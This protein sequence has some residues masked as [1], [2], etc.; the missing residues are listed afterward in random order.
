MF[1][2]ADAC[3][4]I[5]AQ[6]STTFYEAR[7]VSRQNLL[8]I[9]S[10]VKVL[11]R[12]ALPLRGHGSRED[13]NFTQLYIFREED[14]EGLEAWRTEK[15]INKYVHI[16]IQNEMVQIMALR[17]LREVAENIQD[18]NFHSIMCD[19][20]TDIKNISELVV[21]LRWVEDELEAHDEFHVKH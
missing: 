2:I 7:L 20:A 4:D 12:Q 16:T 3:G 5:S 1:T 14:N 17:I 8:K 11:A 18:V 21:C 9:L 6:L 15:K 19:E 13:S 10:N